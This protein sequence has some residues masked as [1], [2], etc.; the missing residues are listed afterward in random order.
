MLTLTA[1]ERFVAIDGTDDMLTISD[2]VL[3]LAVVE[4]VVVQDGAD[5]AQ[6]PAGEMLS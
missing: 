3:K 4:C 5:D 1:L 6:T 2:D